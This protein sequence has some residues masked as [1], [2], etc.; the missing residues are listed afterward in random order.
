MFEMTM[1]CQQRQVCY[2]ATGV[3]NSPEGARLSAG[4]GPR[5]ERLYL[6]HPLHILEHKKKDWQLSSQADMVHMTNF[7][8][9][10]SPRS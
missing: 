4:S 10:H 9:G 2:M 5:T 1:R 6:A 3:K 8:S 7:A